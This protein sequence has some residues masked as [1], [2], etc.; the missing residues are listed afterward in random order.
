MPFRTLF[1]L[2]TLA[3]TAFG[4]EPAKNVDFV[5][6]VQPI[7]EQ[8]CSACHGPKQ[9]LAGLRLD[10]RDSATRVILPGHAADSRLIQM[11]KGSTGK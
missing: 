11:V 10:D 4:A 5:R 2:C 9:H 6:D 7:F 8:H 3:V 1:A